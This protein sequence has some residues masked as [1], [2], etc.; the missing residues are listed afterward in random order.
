MSALLTAIFT[1]IIGWL[2]FD[3]FKLLPMPVIAAILMNIAIGMIDVNLYKNIHS[4]DKVS[5]YITLAVGIITVVDDPIMGIVFGT[6]VSLIIFIGKVSNGNIEI[7]I[8]RDGKFYDK[9]PLLKY[10]K[11]QEE[12]D[13]LIYRL[14]GT[15]NY[16]NIETALD[17]TKQLHKPKAI[18]FNF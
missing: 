7:S 5:F 8:F 1:L 14:A 16:L 12:Q 10:I 11:V 9:L 6:A 4:I 13:T 15:L 18:I 17:Q 3:F 2:L